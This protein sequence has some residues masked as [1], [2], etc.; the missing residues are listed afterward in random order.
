MSGGGCGV[1]ENGL[2]GLK[3]SFLI[4]NGAPPANQAS[5]FGETR[6]Q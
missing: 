4:W 3:W 6:Y 5:T 2:A 1:L